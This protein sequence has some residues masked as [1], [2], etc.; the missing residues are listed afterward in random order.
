MGALGIAYFIVV[1]LDFYQIPCFFQFRNDFFPH[2]K[3]VVSDKKLSGFAHRS[4]IVKNIDSLQ[5]MF[6]SDFVVVNVVSRRN[7]QCSGSEFHIYIFILNNRDF[8]VYQRYN[9]SLPGQMSETRIV[10]IYAYG[11]VS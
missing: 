10:G 6:I 7:F 4:I 11:R 2:F 8:P 1:V 9:T 5:L 3:A